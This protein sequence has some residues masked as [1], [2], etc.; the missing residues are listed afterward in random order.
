[1]KP[2]TK[3]PRCPK[4]KNPNA[5]LCSSCAVKV[6]A[7]DN[8]YDKRTIHSPW[9]ESVGRTTRGAKVKESNE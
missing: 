4:I 7:E 6:A 9:S 1:M 5:L 2:S 3:C 8:P